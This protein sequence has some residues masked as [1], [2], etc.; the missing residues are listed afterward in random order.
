MQRSEK[1]AS[2]ETRE[3]KHEAAGSIMRRISRVWVD[4]KVEE[5][6]PMV[7]A[8][9]VM[10]LPDF[11]GTIQG[12]DQFLAGFRDFCQN[13]KIH[14]FRDDD[15]HIDV[16]GQTAVITFRYEMVYERADQRYHVTG[17]DLWVF[18]EQGRGWVAVWRTMLDT[19]EAAV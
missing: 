7:H 8:D 10:T 3:S 6:A 11:A 15:V 16:A 13:A 2:E 19:D 12:R 1:R 5:L 9:V 17:R 4:G 14:Q 18:Q